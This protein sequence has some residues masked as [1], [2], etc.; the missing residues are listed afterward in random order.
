MRLPTKIVTSMSLLLA[1]CYVDA[2]FANVNWDVVNA[3]FE[4]A[5]NARAALAGAAA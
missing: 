5:Q 3:R 2:F 4:R 1:A